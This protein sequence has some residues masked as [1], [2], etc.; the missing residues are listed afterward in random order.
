LLLSCSLSALA[1]AGGDNDK[2]EGHANAYSGK[3]V[4]IEGTVRCEKADPGYA[5]EVPDRDGHALTLAR[6]KCAWSEPWTIAGAKPKDGVEVSFAE[7]MEGQLHYHGY[8]IDTLDTGDHIT[9][10]MMGQVPAGKGAVEGKGRW[11]FMR[12]TGKFK[13]I[14][15]GGTYEEK[16][17]ADASVTLK[18][19]GVYVPA[20]MAAGKK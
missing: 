14:E 16:V 19:E 3:T 6:R 15:G 2:K 20:G 18:F 10:R 1:Q 12:G 13:G 11:S 5:I 17:A 7:Q 4:Q 9:F 8:E